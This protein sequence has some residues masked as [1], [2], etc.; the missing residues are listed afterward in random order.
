M[1]LQDSNLADAPAPAARAVFVEKPR[2]NAYTAMLAIAFV[3]LVL[4]SICLFAEMKAYDMDWKAAA[5]R[6]PG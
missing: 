3:A 2:A 1:S 6:S 5:A 4:G